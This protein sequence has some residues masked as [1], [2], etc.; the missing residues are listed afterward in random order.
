MRR[1][2]NRVILLGHI[3]RDAETKQPRV[4]S[5]SA[6]SAWPPT[7]SVKTKSG[8]YKDQTDWHNV[9]VWQSKNLAP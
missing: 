5:L 2:V 4:A 9:V 3:G 7:H 6:T 8:G 1:S